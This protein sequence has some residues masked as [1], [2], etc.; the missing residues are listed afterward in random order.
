MTRSQ[1]KGCNIDVDTLESTDLKIAIDGVE[2][3]VCHDKE[4]QEFTSGW[5][6]YQTFGTPEKLAEEV[7]ERFF[8]G[9]EGSRNEN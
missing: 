4:A 6:P 8:A 2:I 3:Q 9:K 5:L 1:Y 7:A